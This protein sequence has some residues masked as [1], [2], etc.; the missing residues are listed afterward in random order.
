MIS[1]RGYFFRGFGIALPLSIK[2]KFFCLNPQIREKK[3][4]GIL[5]QSV[6]KAI[7]IQWAIIH[8][9]FYFIVD[10]CLW[11]IYWSRKGYIYQRLMPLEEIL[12]NFSFTFNLFFAYQKT[13]NFSNR[14]VKWLFLNDR[15]ITVLRSVQVR[16]RDKSGN[17]LT[18]KVTGLFSNNIHG[19]MVIHGVTSFTSHVRNFRFQRKWAWKW[20][21]ED[22]FRDFR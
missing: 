8:D 15:W 21:R 20:D 10:C 18:D 6:S 7:S 14:L 1:R 16:V 3:I 12:E 22:I 5:I 9:L 11:L 17:I 19:F 13:W 2:I 4:F